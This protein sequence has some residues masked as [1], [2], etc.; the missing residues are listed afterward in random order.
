MKAKES[1]NSLYWLLNQ[2]EKGHG[3]AIQAEEIGRTLLEAKEHNIVITL[4]H[5][6]DLYLENIAKENQAQIRSNR[7]VIYEAE[8][9]RHC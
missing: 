7:G 9:D 3:I 5:L 8:K 6:L 2:K 1:A 4:L